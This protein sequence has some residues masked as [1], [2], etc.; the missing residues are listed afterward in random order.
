MMLRPFFYLRTDEPPGGGGDPP[1][2]PTENQVGEA[3]RKQQEAEARAKAA[4]RERDEIK[5]RLDAL[6]SKDDSELQK[7]QRRIA[8]L[9]QERD[10]LKTT[11]ATRDKSDHVRKVASGFNPHNVEAL[12]KHVDLDTINSEDDARAALDTLKQ[13]DPYLFKGDEPAPPPP[14]PAPFGAPVPTGGTP[15]APQVPVKPD[16]SPDVATGVG[17]GLL[18]AID[19]FRTQR[20]GNDAQ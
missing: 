11:L 19:R 5:Q 18:G 3:K 17:M 14:A 7:A 13:S 8:T 12:F 6:E 15:P 20:A 16:G 2:P 1:K 10:T 4:E 9:E